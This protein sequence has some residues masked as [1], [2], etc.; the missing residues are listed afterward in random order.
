MT[1]SNKPGHRGDHEVSRKTIARGMPGRSGVTV[2][3]TL[4]C[5][6]LSAPRLRARWAPGIP[7]ALYS[8][9]GERS[10]K[11]SGASRRGI[12]ESYL[13][14]WRRHAKPVR[15]KR[16]GEGRTRTFEVIRRLIYSQLPL[17][18]GTLPLSTASQ[19]TQ[20][21]WRQGQPMTLKPKDPITGSGRAR[22]WGK[23]H[24][25]VNQGRAPMRAANSS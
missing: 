6:F 16:G 17:P 15:A 9:S 10:C 22:L 18:L 25:K 24:G 21:R 8:R 1:V 20:E 11:T 5:L 12:A 7:C 23:H 13:E 3:T 14:G 4:G 19:P 2:V